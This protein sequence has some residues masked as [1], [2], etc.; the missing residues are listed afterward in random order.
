MVFNQRQLEI[1]MQLFNQTDSFTTAA[2]LAKE[3]EVS[4]RTIQGDLK[5]IKESL[6]KYSCIEF[7]STRKGS[8]IIVKDQDAFLKLKE[9]FL[10]DYTGFSN[11]R[12]ERINELLLCLL[13]Q[14]RSISL[15]DLENELYV[16]QST[17][18]ND[19]KTAKDIASQY[20]LEILRSANRITLDGSE[21]NKRDC[22]LDRNMMVSNTTFL[23]KDT[24]ISELLDEIKAIVIQVFIDFKQTIAD[25]ELSN[26]IILLYIT[27][28]RMKNNFFI[29]PYDLEITENLEPEIHIAEAI[30]K[31]I[32][33]K[34]YIRV[35]QE[36]INY[37]ALYFKGQGSYAELA[38]SNEMDTFI[39]E[40]LTKIK[41]N[42]KF[43]LTDNLN[44]RISLAMHC[45][46]LFIRIK[47]N[48][49]L[50]NPLKDQIRQE[51]PQGYD[52]AS[53]FAYLLQEKFHKHINDSEIAF[54]AIYFY[55]ALTELHETS[56]GK[57]VLCI[58]S[59]RVS[60]NTLL[61]QTFY[62]WFPKKI[63]DLKF[64]DATT[65]EENPSMIDDYDIIATTD[66]D[67]YYDIGLALYVD[68]FPSKKDY[69]NMKLALE[70][71]KNPEDITS[72]FRK[73][74]Y[75]SFEN[76]TKEEIIQ[77]LCFQVEKHFQIEN[78]YD[79]V[80]QRENMRST[81]FG[82]GFAAPH[83]IT[84]ISPDTFVSVG[85]SKKSV[86]WDCDSNQVN[87]VLLIGVGKNNHQAFQ[88]WN[89]IS[90]IFSDTN[91]IKEFSEQP[92]YDNLIQMLRTSLSQG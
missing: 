62:R 83:P 33:N 15:Y 43:D 7:K 32:K 78:L 80:E 36:E 64:V 79:V 66:K 20:N 34:F 41:N 84:P 45:T 82:N 67:K 18:N 9:S 46:P 19:I 90:K 31:E 22:I 40:S 69:Q 16:S 60:E 72:V 58:S 85:Y 39:F 53:Y 65:L 28:N 81:Y 44:L 92:T 26:L 70:G 30:F 24:S 6:S 21:I 89:Y 14:Y 49:Q 73:E 10:L 87:L 11:V 23:S 76:A 52:L 56:N 25:V 27:I 48:M 88:I 54:I 55:S 74:L 5:L 71:F 29:A 57:K 86:S 50:K 77:T 13:N 35:P 68:R 1:T 63:A 42:F 4:L 51:Y 38:V 91:F 61:R 3:K 59:A 8:G 17:L 12:N 47:Y 75:V 2:T 37:L